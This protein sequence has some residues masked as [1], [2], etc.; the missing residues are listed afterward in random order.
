M[1]LMS[2]R[3]RAAH[4]PVGP[5]GSRCVCCDDRKK[6]PTRRAMR[7]VEKRVWKKDEGLL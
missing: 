6:V 5:G 4:R 7:R 1:M 3:N 2:Q